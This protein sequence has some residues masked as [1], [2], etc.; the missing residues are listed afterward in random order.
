MAEDTELCFTIFIENSGHVACLFKIN[1]TRPCVRTEREREP[2]A[3]LPRPFAKSW[4]RRSKRSRDLHGGSQNHLHGWKTARGRVDRIWRPFLS[5]Y[6]TVWV[7]LLWVRTSKIKIYTW[8]FYGVCVR[9]SADIWPEV[10]RLRDRLL[11]QD[12]A[13]ART[14]LS[15]LRGLAKNK[16]RLV[17]VTP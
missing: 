11:R 5:F 4:T 13:P 16:F 17:P 10:W 9:S 12:N 2:T 8:P 14:V 6:S 7:W 15:V 3:H 1:S